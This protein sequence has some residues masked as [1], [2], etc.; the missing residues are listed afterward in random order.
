MI[1]ITSQ[2]Y[3]HGSVHRES[4]WINV[5]WDATIYS[6]LLVYFCKLLALHISGGN[7]THHQ[8]PTGR[9]DHEYSTTVT[10]IRR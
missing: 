2:F 1:E 9:P 3:V 7:S 5:Q 10:T 8:E 6:L 4:M